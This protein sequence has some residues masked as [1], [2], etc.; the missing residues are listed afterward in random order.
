MS[1]LKDKVEYVSGSLV[2]GTGWGVT[3]S[4]S[5]SA[6]VDADWGTVLSTSTEG[7]SFLKGDATLEVDNKYKVATGTV[8]SEYVTTSTN[9]SEWGTLESQVTSGTSYYKQTAKY[10]D[11][12]LKHAAKDI[13]DNP[14]LNSFAE[15]NAA[16][17]TG[18]YETY[19]N[20]Q[21][22]DGVLRGTI[23]QWGTLADSMTIGENYRWKD[24]SL[25]SDY[26]TVTEYDVNF[27]ITNYSETVGRSYD[28]DLWETFSVNAVSGGYTTTVDGAIIGAF[29]TG[30]I[31]DYT[32][33]KYNEFGENLFSVTVGESYRLYGND[34][35]TAQVA[36]TGRYT[37]HTTYEFGQTSSGSTIGVSFAYGDKTGEYQTYN[38]YDDWGEQTHTVNNG[39]SGKMVRLKAGGEYYDK[40]SEYSTTTYMNEF[41]E[42]EESYSAGTKFKSGLWTEK[43]TSYTQFE[44]G[45]NSYSRNE[46]YNRFGNTLAYISESTFD[47]S[48]ATIS[49]VTTNDDAV[50]GIYTSTTHFTTDNSSLYPSDTVVDYTISDNTDDDRLAG[51]PAQVRTDYD[52]EEVNFTGSDGVGYKAS[53]MLSM[54]QNDSRNTETYYK[55]HSLFDKDPQERE[56]EYV[57]AD[58]S[59]EDIALGGTAQVRTDYTW[60]EEDVVGDDALTR[61]ASVMGST[62]ATD[63]KMTYTEYTTDA[64]SS[65]YQDRSINYTETNNRFED[66]AKG[67]P[68]RVTTQYY[69]DPVF[70]PNLRWYDADAGI[71]K[72]GKIVSVIGRTETDDSTHTRTYYK[73]DP[74]ETDVR[75]VVYD[76]II[77]DS[78][79]RDLAG[80]QSATKRTDYFWEEGT[81]SHAGV[82][83]YM[84]IMSRT[85]TYDPNT[86]SIIYD[87]TVYT[88]SPSMDMYRA[89]QVS[90]KDRV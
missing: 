14:D 34:V 84:S 69:W 45:R 73:A 71:I 16:W 17:T 8:V 43:Y 68:D 76:Y 11:G 64:H 31:G 10:E 9:D 48:G 50:R 62:Q 39:T 33:G 38:Y 44:N 36:V 28:R 52:Y 60:V 56:I 7:M 74:Y 2:Y 26:T 25:A 78:T 35:N 86:P 90:V 79:E 32:T 70:D 75:K 89:T 81:E 66:M 30:T 47:D 4:Y 37:T 27:G 40:R 19:A 15:G 61:V 42:N 3:G 29:S 49:S 54:K 82:T 58:N 51:G 57:L 72:T 13:D 20:A 21:D 85:E 63:S 23:D 59:K 53:A 6:T 46:G 24:G 87:V 65:Y 12:I 55:E 83:K 77:T 88:T 5:T 67:G 18:M 80:G 41:G 1:Y 22:N